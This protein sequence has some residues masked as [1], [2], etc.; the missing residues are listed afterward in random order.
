[1]Y[2]ITFCKYRGSILDDLLDG[3]TFLAY[4]FHAIS[5]QKDANIT[6]PYEVIGLTSFSY[7]PI[8]G[9]I[10]EVYDQ[11]DN[12]EIDYYDINNNTGKTYIGGLMIGNTTPVLRELEYSDTLLNDLLASSLYDICH[13][14]L[15]GAYLYLQSAQKLMSLYG[16][17]AF[18]IVST[19]R[20][21]TG[22]IKPYVL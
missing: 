5:N 11:F 14:D 13:N 22:R 3:A 2:P 8:V 19:K 20:K 4:S 15:T 6:L 16:Q 18:D 21:Q 9:P 12:S 10:A 17:S 7:A 1:M